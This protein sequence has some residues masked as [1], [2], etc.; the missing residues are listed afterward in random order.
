MWLMSH[1]RGSTM[2][3]GVGKLLV[4]ECRTNNVHV[5]R[6]KAPDVRPFL[7]DYVDMSESELFQELEEYILAHFAPGHGLVLNLAPIEMFNTAVL[8]FL[9]LVRKVVHDRKGCLVL[10]QVRD[11]H[12]EV[13][14]V[15]RTF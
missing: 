5:V 2:K 6:F 12:F 8:R 1:L 11:E 15:T 10:C 4:A 13:F 7:D 3:I 14:S 9:L